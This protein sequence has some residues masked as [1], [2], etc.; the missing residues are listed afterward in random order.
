[1]TA[2]T[3][4]LR[5]LACA[6]SFSA[7]RS[8]FPVVGVAYSATYC[9]RWVLLASASPDTAVDHIAC[10]VLLPA[11]ASCF[12]V[13]FA[14]VSATMA[15]NCVARYP[16]FPR[17]GGA[18]P[19]VVKAYQQPDRPPGEL[20]VH[21]ELRT[22]Q[23]CLKF[24]AAA[25]HT[26]WWLL[27]CWH[28]WFRELQC[29]DAH[30]QLQK[31]GGNLDLCRSLPDLPR[32]PFAEHT[33]GTRA[34]VHLL[35]VWSEAKDLAL[36]GSAAELRQCML[37]RVLRSTLDVRIA[38]PVAGG[39]PPR[40]FEVTIEG[41][42]LR[43]EGLGDTDDR[44]ASLLFLRCQ[45][46][47]G[48]GSSL[49]SLVDIFQ[50]CMSCLG[51]W[52][53]FYKQLVAAVSYL[54]DEGF[55]ECEFDRGP[56]RAGFTI[57]PKRRVD[58][59]VSSSLALGKIGD[60]TGVNSS[61]M[62]Q[63][64]GGLGLCGDRTYEGGEEQVMM[65]YWESG[66]FHFSHCDSLSIAADASEVGGQSLMFVCVCGRAARGLDEGRS[67]AAWPPPQVVRDARDLGAHRWGEPVAREFV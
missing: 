6:T 50:V 27:D 46:L 11:Q 65:R 38:L 5:P 52:L 44:S 10:G 35:N 56:W 54:F 9:G 30:H 4:G 23:A 48:D 21:W 12:T 24:S 26:C 57:A 29:I 59:D 15:V 67:F 18:R 39:R 53:W 62:R 47:D 34:L 49:I 13:P 28:F 25:N 1:M 45:R 40:A 22:I 32:N 31:A 14:A 43:F 20:H 51:R 36:V 63:V 58:L 64:L 42:N 16:S 2:R 55:G 8:A 33:V 17:D 19:A 66:R 37:K 60:T 7:R 41:C 61:T 3:R